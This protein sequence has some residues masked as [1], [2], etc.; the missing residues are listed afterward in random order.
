M[1]GR[2]GFVRRLAGGMAAAA[3]AGLLLAGVLEA[4]V[5]AAPGDGIGVAAPTAGGPQA[6][7]PAQKPP[8]KKDPVAKA[9]EPWP[10]AERLA[11]RRTEAESLPLFGSVDPLAFT[12]TADFRTINR[13]RDPESTKRYTGVLQL[14]GEGGVPPV[15]VQLS[16]RGH[17]RRNRA[18][19]AVVP[20]RL[21]FAKADLKGTVFAGQRELKLVTHCDNDDDHEQYVL[22]EYLA[23]RLYGLF[24]PFA[25]RARLARVTYVDPARKGTPVARYGILLE[26]DEDVARRMEG[27]LYPFNNRLFR[28]L[29]REAVITMT[30]LQFMIGNSDYSI[31]AL[32]NVK[33]VRN[34]G[35]VTYPIGYDFDYSGLVNAPYAIADPRLHIKTVRDRLYRGPCLMLGELDPLRARVAAKKDEALALIDAVPGLKATRRADAREY[36]SDFFSLMASPSRAKRALIDN[37]TQASGM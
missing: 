30:L 23:Y 15:P 6:S 3:L 10:D 29:D 25:F 13:D 31:M 34:Q 21:E 16:A 4:R 9:E 11:Q 33:L 32:H 28:F 17:A 36:L 12:L 37:C 7:A 18:V 20:L 35:G 2:R 22:T 26:N 8:A 14:P 1:T 27:R 24:T 5:S 19:C